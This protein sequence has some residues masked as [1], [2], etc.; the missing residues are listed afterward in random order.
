MREVFETDFLFRFER[1]CV[2]ATA[3]VDF[4]CFVHFHTHYIF[5]HLPL[6]LLRTQFHP[7][8]VVTVL[9]LW[10]KTWTPSSNAKHM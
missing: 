1:A 2:A 10:I 4:S 5:F 3:T 6:P 8:I 7:L 9:S